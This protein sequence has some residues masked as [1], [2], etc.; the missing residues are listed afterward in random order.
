[1][2]SEVAPAAVY[3]RAKPSSSI[4]PDRNARLIS[5]PFFIRE[6]APLATV[7]N[8]VSD[9]KVMSYASEDTRGRKA[10]PLTPITTRGANPGLLALVPL[11]KSA[12]APVTF[13]EDT[14]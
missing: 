11:D 10:E 13:L 14:S 9:V 3:E 12:M 7:R 6:W 4:T 8:Y 2:R 5:P 1:M